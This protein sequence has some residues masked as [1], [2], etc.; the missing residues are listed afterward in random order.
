MLC[1]W[2]YHMAHLLTAETSREAAPSPRL[3]YVTNLRPSCPYATRVNVVAYLE[4]STVALTP[5]LFEY[6]KQP[7][8]PHT[9]HDLEL[10]RGRLKKSRRHLT[11]RKNTQDCML[12]D[13]SFVAMLCGL[14]HTHPWVD[15][16]PHVHL[17]E[18]RPT[19]HLLR[20]TEKRSQCWHAR[21]DVAA[22]LASLEQPWVPHEGVLQR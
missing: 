12:R 11:G 3:T 20:Q 16:F 14:P 4:K 22:Y 21:H 5:Q 8:G 15:A 9:H 7:L 1:S 19:L 13:G 17:N 10:F 2:M 6:L 18:V